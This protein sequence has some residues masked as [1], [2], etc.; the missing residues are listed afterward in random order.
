MHISYSLGFRLGFTAA[1]FPERS[2]CWP[3]KMQKREPF[4]IY[5]YVYIRNKN[6]FPLL[7]TRWSTTSPRAYKYENISEFNNN[8]Q[9][10]T[11]SRVTADVDA[12]GLT[13]RSFDNCY[14]SFDILKISFRILLMAVVPQTSIASNYQSSTLHPL[15]TARLNVTSSP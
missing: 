3:L 7:Y 14:A 4:R 13:R 9:E 1:V 6:N 15:W 10:Q 5:K 11:T 12:D 8:N 2:V